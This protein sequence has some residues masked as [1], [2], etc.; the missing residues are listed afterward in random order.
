MIK[1]IS[2]W[3]FDPAR[4]LPEVFRLA[5][6]HGFAAVE[7]TIA[8]TGPITPTTTAE[9]CETII[10]ATRAA[11]IQ[12]ASLASGLGWLYPLT[13]TDVAVR[14]RGIELTAG[15]L[16]VAALLGLDTLL[17][18]PGVVSTPSGDT[19]LAAPYDV[20]LENLHCSLQELTPVAEE[21]RVA[22]A[23]ENVWNKFLLSPLEMRTMIDVQNSDFVGCYFDVGNILLTSYPE[24]WIHILGHRIKR[25]HFKDWQRRVG[26]LDGFCPLLEG[27]VNYPLVM[28]ALYDIGYNSFVT[29]EYFE[30]ESDLPAISQ[31][32]SRILAM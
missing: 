18:V 26:T 10:R 13:S 1:S 27:D 3:A 19:T 2:A 17:V 6:E 21:W 9:E 29:S 31:A 25:I 20:A 15:S 11:D 4:P 32:M 23:L 24:Q 22:I 28:Q 7:V 14:R 12:L 30:C 5:R 16:R 8:E